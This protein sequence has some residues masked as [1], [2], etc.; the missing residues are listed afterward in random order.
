M[1][2]RK[3]RRRKEIGEGEEVEEWEEATAMDVDNVAIRSWNKEREERVKKLSIASRIR[4]KFNANHMSVAHVCCCAMFIKITKF[5]LSR[6][7]CARDTY[8]A[9]A[10]HSRAR[11]T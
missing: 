9:H 6:H 8:A 10:R 5:S 3:G 1:M 11:N 7:S 4:G 2:K